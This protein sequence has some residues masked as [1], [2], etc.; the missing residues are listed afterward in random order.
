[1]P[2]A[3]KETQWLS[4]LHPAGVKPCACGSAKISKY[5]E[6]CAD[7]TSEA[8][9][10]STSKFQYRDKYELNLVHTLVEAMCKHDSRLESVTAIRAM[11][12]LL[13][14]TRHNR[15]LRIN[16]SELLEEGV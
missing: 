2:E 10:I 13:K 3:K 11:E 14:S 15:D 16:L 1:M 6:A 5:A 4:P 12:A 7:C 9:R 8:F